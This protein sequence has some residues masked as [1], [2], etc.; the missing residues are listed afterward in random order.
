MTVQKLLHKPVVNVQDVPP[1][2]PRAP[3]RRDAAPRV[4]RVLAEGGDGAAHQVDHLGLRR[5]PGQ[6]PSGHG[7]RLWR[8]RGLAVLDYYQRDTFTF[9]SIINVHKYLFYV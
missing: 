7:Q 9:Y 8:G 1:A 6:A 2:L 4:V 3:T 5:A